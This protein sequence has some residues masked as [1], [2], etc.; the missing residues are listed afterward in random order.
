MGFSC[1]ETMTDWQRQFDALA[2]WHTRFKIG[3]QEYGGGEFLPD[4]VLEEK[5]FQCFP[6]AKTVL[7]LGCCEGGRTILLAP[8]L[9]KLVCVEGQGENLKRARFVTKT[10]GLDVEFHHLDLETAGL[11]FLGR[12]DAV[13]LVGVLYHLQDPWHLLGELAKLT[14]RVFIWTH[15][16]R[17]EEADFELNGIP[18]KKY[19]EPISPFAGLR[20]WSFWPTWKG[21]LKLIGQFFRFAEV[22]EHTSHQHGPCATLSAWNN[23][24]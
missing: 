15:Y 19:L 4:G 22:L 20:P 10:L 3:D 11:E 24:V 6:E 12:F 16:C 17:D 9:Q 7:E 2:P 1:G 18:G 13:Y 5:F 23:N 21:L 14:D 8:H